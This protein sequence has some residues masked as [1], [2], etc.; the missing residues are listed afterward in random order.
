MTKLGCRKVHKD[1]LCPLRRHVCKQG[2][3]LSRICSC[4]LFIMANMEPGETSATCAHVFHLQSAK[5]LFGVKSRLVQRLSFAPLG[6]TYAQLGCVVCPRNTQRLC[7]C[8]RWA[9]SA[10][11]LMELRQHTSRWHANPEGSG[12]ETNNSKVLST[13][14]RL[15]LQHAK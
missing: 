8:L 14:L 5:G 2:G 4:L 9:L 3:L 1:R 13:A 10:D 6:R 11:G 7:L 12:V 15:S